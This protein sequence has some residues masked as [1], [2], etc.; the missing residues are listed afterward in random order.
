MKSK[1]RK[2]LTTTCGVRD[3]Y[4]ATSELN[5]VAIFRRKERLVPP[6]ETYAKYFPDLYSRD[7]KAK[8]AAKAVLNNPDAVSFLLRKLAGMEDAIQAAPIHEVI[9]MSRDTTVKEVGYFLDDPEKAV[10]VGAFKSFKELA[11]LAASDEGVHAQV[12]DFFLHE[13]AKAERGQGDEKRM[14]AVNAM[15][16]AINEL[17]TEDKKARLRALIGK[18]DRRGRVGG[19][20]APRKRAKAA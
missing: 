2:L 15:E 20:G 1:S 7:E 13:K 14:A 5:T 11:K 4:P 6:Q 10:R 19:F 18:P 16:A 3:F 17:P 12:T 9:Q 8:W